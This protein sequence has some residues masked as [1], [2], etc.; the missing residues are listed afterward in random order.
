MPRSLDTEGSPHCVGDVG[1]RRL[2]LWLL[3][4]WDSGD[5]IPFIQFWRSLSSMLSAASRRGSGES[6][7]NLCYVG[8]AGHYPHRPCFTLG[9]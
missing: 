9:L 6:V 7:M 3:K 1:Y 2:T 8:G 4:D 5:N